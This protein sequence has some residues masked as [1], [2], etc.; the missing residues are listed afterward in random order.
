MMDCKYSGVRFANQKG[1]WGSCSTAGVISLNVALMKLP[2]A[3]IDYVLVH[4][5]AHTKHMNH[6]ADF[7]DLVEQ[8]YPEYRLARKELR[9]YSPYL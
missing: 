6:S 1:R 2:E 8:Y 5:L 7:W 9:D 4:E 3:L